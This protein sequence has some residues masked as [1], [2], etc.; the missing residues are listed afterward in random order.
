MTPDVVVCTNLLSEGARSEK[1][2]AHEAK[3]NA[4]RRRLFAHKLFCHT[5]HCA[6]GISCALC[7]A[8]TAVHAPTG[9]L[10]GVR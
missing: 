9:S 7:A 1:R 8:K 6:H 4:I 10:R 5:Y 2:K 3:A